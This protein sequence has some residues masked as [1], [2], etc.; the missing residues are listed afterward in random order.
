MLWGP[1][2]FDSMRAT[3]TRGTIT[4]RTPAAATGNGSSAVGATRMAR[5]ATDTTSITP[6]RMNGRR[7][8]SA[9]PG[10]QSETATPT[11]LPTAT[12]LAAAI[13]ENPLCVRSRAGI[14]PPRPWATK[15]TPRPSARISRI[16]GS[17]PRTRQ[18][19]TAPASV[20]SLLD[21]GAWMRPVTTSQPARARTIEPVSITTVQ[22]HDPVSGMSTEL[23]S[24]SVTTPPSA[25]AVL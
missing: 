23:D 17:R 7:R 6:A 16:R 4:A 21:I 2:A 20:A 19:P 11:P 10:S 13:D 9:F 15:K 22:R 24:T 3:S 5:S 25:G 14:Q 1:T 12:Q 8:P 18:A